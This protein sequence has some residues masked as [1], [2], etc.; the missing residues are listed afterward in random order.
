MVN[1]LP[2]PSSMRSPDVADEKQ[3]SASSQR[4]ISLLSLWGVRRARLFLTRPATAL[5]VSLQIFEVL[6]PTAMRIRPSPIPAPLSA[7]DN[8]P[9]VVVAGWTIVVFRQVAVTTSGACR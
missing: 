5:A 4:L 8:R 6:Q 3:T 1:A 9:W 2:R 7:D